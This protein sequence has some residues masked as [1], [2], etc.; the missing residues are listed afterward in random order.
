M[1]SIDFNDKEAQQLLA[2][3]AAKFFELEG[4]V[5]IYKEKQTGVIRFIK[6]PRPKKEDIILY[7]KSRVT[8]GNK[9]TALDKI[10]G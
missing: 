6:Q 7:D 3:F 2:L 10:V 4:E 9:K 5:L 8:K 1:I